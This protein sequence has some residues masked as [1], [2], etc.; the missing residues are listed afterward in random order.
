MGERP[1]GK[2]IERVDNDAGYSK[3][4][5]CW[6]TYHEQ[7]LNKRLQSNN[8]TGVRGVYRITAKSK[9]RVEIKKHGIKTHIGY[10]DNFED[11]VA[12]RRAAELDKFGRYV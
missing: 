1:E 5:C 2:S 9:W 7:S 10:F 6:A 11:A 12:A 4:N 8:V 3:E